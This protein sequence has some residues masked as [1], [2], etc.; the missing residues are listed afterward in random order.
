M[1]GN[2][3]WHH[4]R[5]ERGEKWVSSDAAVGR[6]HWCSGL[7]DSRP[8]G[9]SFGG[10]ARGGAA[11]SPDPAL[12][13]ASGTGRCA[14]L[15]RGRLSRDTLVLT[16]PGH[17]ESLAHAV[18]CLV[19]QSCPTL[20]DSRDCS[21]PGSSVHGIL[22]AR[23]LEWVFTLLQGIFPKFGSWTRFSGGFYILD[24]AFCSF[25]RAFRWCIFVHLA[26]FKCGG[27]APSHAPSLRGVPSA[28]SGYQG[29]PLSHLY[30]A[31]HPLFYTHSSCR[32]C[33]GSGFS[34]LLFTP[35]PFT[36]SSGWEVQ[37]PFHFLVER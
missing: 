4:E 24:C 19:A 23:K 37:Q 11:G 9:V 30:P 12:S 32:N 2:Q 16:R 20:C 36:T 6:R 5:L 33:T 27:S 8:P 31:S 21:L 3:R 1:T 10:A 15:R 14:P 25:Y 34:S 28:A 22:Q 26:D 18:L 29:A 7:K 17:W 13:S 35:T